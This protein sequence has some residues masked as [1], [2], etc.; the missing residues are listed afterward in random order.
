MMREKCTLKQSYE[1]Y[2]MEREARCHEAQGYYS[3][4]GCYFH[5]KVDAINEDKILDIIG[6]HG[7]DLIRE[8]H[9]MEPCGII[10]GRKLYAL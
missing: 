9:L 2:E 1:D 10:N 3:V 7:L 5:W 4:L 8:F 6:Q